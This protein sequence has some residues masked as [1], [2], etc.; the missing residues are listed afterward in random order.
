MIHRDAGVKGRVVVEWFVAVDFRGQADGFDGG[1]YFK[2]EVACSE[3]LGI[4]LRRGLHHFS[5]TVLL[6]I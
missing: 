3:L 2:G 1:L 4:R 5:N 6:N